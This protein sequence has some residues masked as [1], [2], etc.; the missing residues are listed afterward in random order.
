LEALVQKVQKIEHNLINKVGCT[1][2]IKTLE[3][4]LAVLIKNKIKET[5]SHCMI[6]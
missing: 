5:I 2:I 6:Y 4:I 1:G 3:N